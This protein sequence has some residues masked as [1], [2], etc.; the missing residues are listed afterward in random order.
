MDLSIVFGTYNRLRLLKDCVA[1][2]RATIGVLEYEIIVADAGSTDG[3]REWLATQSD[4]VLLGERHLNGAIVAFNKAFSLARGWAV[5]NI[6]DDIV[7]I[8]DCLP[9]A[10]DY[11]RQHSETVAQ[12]AFIFDTALNG[13]FRVGDTIHGRQAANF[14]MSQKLLGDYVGWWGTTYHTY[15]GDTE[16]SIK[17]WQIGWRVVSLPEC[18][19]HH[20]QAHDALRRLDNDAAEHFWGFWTAD[21]VG[22]FPTSPKPRAEIEAEMAKRKRL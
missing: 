3:S 22:S 4:V 12:V 15:G 9:R 7:M 16:V 21:L 18:R 6:N 14:G 13:Q 11:L 2:I 8:G 1:S 5:A 20:L 19:V 17:Y 10:Y